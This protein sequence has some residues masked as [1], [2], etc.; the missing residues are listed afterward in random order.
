MSRRTVR[1]M[2][3]LLVLAVIVILASFASCLVRHSEN[4]TRSAPFFYGALCIYLN[5]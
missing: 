1:L 5:T 4:Q 3:I 2:Q